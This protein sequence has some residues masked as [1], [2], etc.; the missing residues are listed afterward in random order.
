MST[1]QKFHITAAK[2]IK[3][4]NHK[5]CTVKFGQYNSK[6]EATE[7]LKKLGDT[8]PKST[9]K[10]AAEAKSDAP[11]TTIAKKATTKKAKKTSEVSSGAKKTTKKTAKKA[12]TPKK[13]AITTTPKAKAAPKAKKKETVD[14]QAA[15]KPDDVKLP[16]VEEKVVTEK[17]KPASDYFA[18]DEVFLLDNADEILA[19]TISSAAVKQGESLI[20]WRI[21]GLESSD[22]KR[23]SAKELKN[24]PPRLF[25]ESDSGESANFVLTKK[26]AITMAD[27]LDSVRRAYFNVSPRKA[28]F[29]ENGE[30]V[31][32]HALS[33]ITDHPVRSTIIAAF[34]VIFVSVL[35]LS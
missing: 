21:E 10:K 35:V 7:A 28:R 33:W 24:N 19:S 15:T 32:S 20:T 17:A 13:K 30:E 26:L 34:A 2:E 6:K 29:D 12:T 14:D 1:A 11:S 25:V 8:N 9:T 4:C 27:S 5:S 16:A 31:A 23:L 18:D 3:P 22:G